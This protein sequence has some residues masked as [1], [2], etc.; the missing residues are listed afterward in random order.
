MTVIHDIISGFV[1]LETDLRI[2]GPPPS[3][4]IDVYGW[5]NYNDKISHIIINL[6]AKIWGVIIGSTSAT[7]VL[8]PPPGRS[9]LT[10]PIPLPSDV[11][12]IIEGE[13]VR[14]SGD[15]EVELLITCYYVGLPTTLSYSSALTVSGPHNYDDKFTVSLVEWKN[16]LGLKDFEPLLVSRSSVS[17]LDELR[18]KWGLFTH[19]DV[20]IRLTELYEGVKIERPYELLFTDP[21]IKTIKSKLSSLVESGM[22]SEVYAVSL[23]LDHSG[24]EYLMKLRKKGA[25]IKLLTRKPDKK[26]YIDAIKYLRDNYVEVKFNNMAHARFIVFDEDV[27][28]VMTADLDVNG[29]DNQRQIGVYITDRAT[30]KA[31]KAFFNKLWEESEP[32]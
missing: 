28:I 10:L 14:K 8:K 11:I 29:L 5:H 9:G 3:L 26:E 30:V 12:R 15:V 4:Q 7:I 2:S 17:K 31:C 23:Y 18:H 1:R 13:R 6:N 32:S 16:A 27:A 25:H 24:A 21:E 20:L 22:W 19:E